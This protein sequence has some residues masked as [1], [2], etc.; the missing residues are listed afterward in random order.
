MLPW[1]LAH[2]G[3]QRHPLAVERVALA[4]CDAR[5]IA[6]VAL[7]RLDVFESIDVCEL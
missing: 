6:D 7:H 5:D 3:S 4:R 1:A 2:S